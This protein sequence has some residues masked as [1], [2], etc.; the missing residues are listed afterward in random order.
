M[1]KF[2]QI[3]KSLLVVAAIGVFFVD[4]RVAV[5]ILVTAS[6][7]HTIPLG[8]NALLNTITGYLMIGGIVAFFYDWRLAVGLI[9][10]GSLVAKFHVWGNRQN[11]EYYR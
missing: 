3:L 4:W 5:G 8:P 7:I 6:V 1:L 9:V 11:A 10:V 2:L